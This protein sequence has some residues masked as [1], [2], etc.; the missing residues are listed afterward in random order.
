MSR[1]ALFNQLAGRLSELRRRLLPRKFSSTGVYTDR[2]LDAARGYRVLAHAEI[3][4]YIEQSAYFIANQAFANWRNDSRP[5]KAIICLLAHSKRPERGYTDTSR[6]VGDAIAGLGNVIKG[7]HGIKEENLLKLLPP[8]GIEW[9]ALNTTWLATMTSFGTLR[10]QVAHSSARAQHPI[11][12]LTEFN[13]V[14]FL[15]S[16]LK[17][18]DDMFEVLK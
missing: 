1:S 10:G 16:G 7:N 18:L 11:D 12:P 15:L 13:T 6:H 14:K 2:Q 5:R 4:H 8:V 3:E 9:S 17:D